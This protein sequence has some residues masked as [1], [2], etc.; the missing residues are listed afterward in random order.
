MMDSYHLT[1]AE[2]QI[3]VSQFTSSDPLGF[4]QTF[5]PLISSASYT[6]QGWSKPKL[7]PIEDLQL[8]PITRVL[9]YGQAIFEG[10]KAFKPAPYIQP[11]LFRPSAYF[12]RFNQSAARMGMPAIDED[13]FM[14]ALEGL[15][16]QLA[17]II[18][19]KRG[20][21]LYIRPIMI[22]ADQNLLLE[23][24]KEFL[25]VIMAS[26]S[27]GYFSAPI[28]VMIERYFA[29]AVAGGTGIAKAAG[30]YGGAFMPLMQA[31]KQ[32]YHQILWLDAIEKRYIE[33]FSAMNFFAVINGA[34]Y[35]P[36]LTDTILAGITR[37]SLLV[38]AK[39]LGIET[40]EVPI[41]IDDLIKKIKS[42]ECTEIFACGTGA[43]I[44]PVYELGEKSGEKY[45]LSSSSHLSLTH[46]LK[47][48]LLNIQ[49]GISSPPDQWLHWVTKQ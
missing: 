20:Q 8:S 30:N 10:M 1:G 44:T 45:I 7:L 18:P 25:F 17:P 23:E 11:C 21:S 36:Q 5:A 27:D 12:N 48:A 47:E 32:G 40:F 33:E 42:G 4:C 41:S 16:Y 46:Q 35:T 31:K 3:K 39:T 15:V 34:I 6:C 43:I 13:I 29:R 24:A 14:E 9:H 49:M 26:P 2:L 37:D 38:L 19:N 28:S 22:A